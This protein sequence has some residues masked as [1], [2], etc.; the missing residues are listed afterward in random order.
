MEDVKFGPHQLLD[1]KQRQ[2]EKFQ[3]HSP[4]M[5]TGAPLPFEN[6]VNFFPKAPSD[7]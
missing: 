4:L 1:E 7:H 3:N 6:T 2:I 5:G